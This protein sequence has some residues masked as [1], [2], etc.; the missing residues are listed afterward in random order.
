VELR[1]H[2]RGASAATRL[3]RSWSLTEVEPRVTLTAV[4]APG[5]KPRI[6]LAGGLFNSA[7]R[8]HNLMLEKH[9]RDLG[10][11]VVLPQ[12]EATRF[13]TDEGFDLAGIVADCRRQCT[14]GET[15]LVGS[16]DGAD[17]DSGTSVEYG[18]SI[19][20]TGRAIVYR[21]DLRTEMSKEV[22]LN[23]MFRA[24][25]S[26]LV[27]L[28]CHVTELDQVDAYYRD[29]ASK[30]HDAVGRLGQEAAP[31]SDASPIPGRPTS[32]G[33]PDATAAS[34][35]PAAGTTSVIESAS[36]KIARERIEKVVIGFLVSLVLKATLDTAYGEAAKH[37]THVADLVLSDKSINVLAFLIT[38]VRF[39]FGVYR[40][41]EEFAGLTNTGVKLSSVARAFS[42]SLSVVLF[43]AFYL[44]GLLITTVD[45]F[46]SGLFVAH[47][48]DALWFTVMWLSWPRW[49]SNQ[50]LK[51]IFGHFILIDVVTCELIAVMLLGG[52]QKH[53]EWVGLVIM[54]AVA[55][56]DTKL[57]APFF[58]GGLRAYEAWVGMKRLKRERLKART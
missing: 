2:D 12:R 9:L 39:V 50:T 46:Y 17:A 55:A 27:Y 18:M 37:T 33:P 1:E 3:L 40:L 47:V 19:V 13:Q 21:T 29:L 34:T 35:A 38:I 41:G 32:E 6:Y 42:F 11:E 10:Y 28:P 16:T 31:P 58:A 52:P 48:C 57:H 20:A 36:D 51:T 25:R 44:S 14:D 54:L 43:L 7:E 4:T 26:E 23:A 53:H 8:V 45:G 30:I 24:S 49:P 22:G 15:L 5:T 56:L